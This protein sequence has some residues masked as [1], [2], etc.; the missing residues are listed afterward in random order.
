MITE[1][2]DTLYTLGWALLGW[3][4]VLSAL[5]TVIVLAI[6]AA[7]WWTGAVVWRLIRRPRPAR[8]HYEE[9]A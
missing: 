3:V 2:L 1:A 5:F 8:D 9:A 6:V 4:V 7:V